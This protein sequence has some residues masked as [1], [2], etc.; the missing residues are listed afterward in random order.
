M[1]GGSGWTIR[2][3]WLLAAFPA[4]ERLMLRKLEGWDAG[5]RPLASFEWIEFVIGRRTFELGVF[6]RLAY[7]FGP[8]ILCL[9]FFEADGST[10]FSRLFTLL[11]RLILLVW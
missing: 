4:A 11:K 8:S 10:A 6:I 7:R 9:A 2:C 5:T 3:I 1:L